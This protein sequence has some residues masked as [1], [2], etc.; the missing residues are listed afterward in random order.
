MIMLKL[1]VVDVGLGEAF[2]SIASIIFLMVGLVV[3]VLKV[4]V[5]DV[6]L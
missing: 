1:L 2:G 3:M 5:V 6:G 4:L